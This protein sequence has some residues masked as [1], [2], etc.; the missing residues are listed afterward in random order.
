MARVADQRR[1][2]YFIS[3]VCRQIDGVAKIAGSVGAPPIGL[4]MEA[5]GEI[6]IS[7]IDGPPPKGSIGAREE[8]C[9]IPI[10]HFEGKAVFPIL[11]VPIDF[12]V[13][14]PPPLGLLQVPMDPVIPVARKKLTP[15]RLVHRG[16]EA[17][18]KNKEK[19]NFHNRM[20]AVR[21]DQ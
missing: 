5:G 18:S 14:E 8:K 2:E 7:L 20:G 16:K 10:D 11:N 15:K 13:G 21:L 12:A 1:E 4:E 17:R 3:P 19:D 6:G 9:E